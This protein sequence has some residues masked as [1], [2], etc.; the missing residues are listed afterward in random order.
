MLYRFVTGLMP[1][2]TLHHS[3]SIFKHWRKQSLS[4]TES[5]QPPVLVTG[6]VPS[7]TGLNRKECLFG[8]VNKREFL[9]KSHKKKLT[10]ML[11]SVARKVTGSLKSCFLCHR[12]CTYRYLILAIKLSLDQLHNRRCTGK[13]RPVN[14]RALTRDMLSANK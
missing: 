5:I 13:K 9:L 11:P 4:T 12:M 10:A 6:S 14:L 8:T 1:F 3:R 2:L 7:K